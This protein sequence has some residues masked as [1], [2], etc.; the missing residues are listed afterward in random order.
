VRAWGK[1]EKKILEKVNEPIL[2]VFPFFCFLIL[3]KTKTQDNNGKGCHV[4]PTS[5][6]TSA[7][8]AIH[9]AARRSVAW[10]HVKRSRQS[11]DL[12]PA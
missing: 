10:E 3:T 8:T 6:F 4:T 12:H 9:F 7:I 5:L 2:L 1:M 11:S